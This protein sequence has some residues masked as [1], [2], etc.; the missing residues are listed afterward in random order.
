MVLT[1][2]LVLLAYSFIYYDARNPLIL[3]YRTVRVVSVVLSGLV[4]GFNA[5]YLQSCLRNPLVDHYILGVGSG[6]V[7]ATYL[8]L[9]VFSTN[10]IILTSTF[11]AIGGLLALAI[12][13]IVAEYLGGSDYAYI[14][15]GI[16]V[17]SLFSGLSIL[18]SH[19]VLKRL[20]LP[21][22]LMLIGSFVNASSRNIPYLVGTLVVTLTSYPFLS[23]PL[24]TLL[25]GDDYAKQLGYN[26]RVTRFTAIVVAGVTTSIVVSMHGIIGFIGLVSPHLSRLAL[27]TADQRFIAPS[28]A[29]LSSLLLLV[30]DT[31]SRTVLTKSI[32]EVPAGA[33]V[34]VIGA[35]LFVS[36]LI[37]R[38][39]R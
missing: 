25:L 3:K 16:G 23:K 39:K 15:V 4:I 9:T 27:R 26:P 19:A 37:S 10:L 2:A 18:I 22:L 5:S 7:F 1:L 12:T 24:N 31:L 35:P 11:A 8:S 6:A 32:G 21:P 20:S 13:I 30:T 29:L 28:S 36:M 38:F 14:L 34:S 17:N 33:I